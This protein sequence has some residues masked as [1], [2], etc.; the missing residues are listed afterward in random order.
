MAIL[1]MPSRR[2][3][4]EDAIEVHLMLLRGELQSRVAAH[5]DTN[6]GRISE[7]KT[8]KKHIGSREDAIKRLNRAA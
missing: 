7:I 5:F 3:T 4:Y 8:G 1:R 6:I 2:L